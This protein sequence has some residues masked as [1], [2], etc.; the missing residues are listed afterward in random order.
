MDFGF[1]LGNHNVENPLYD[2]TVWADTEGQKRS[3]ACRSLD[4]DGDSK[5][6]YYEIG[7]ILRLALVRLGLDKG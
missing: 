4:G 7:T 6:Y 1:E 5:T 2:T 3:T